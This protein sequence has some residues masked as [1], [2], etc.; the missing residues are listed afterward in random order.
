[1]AWAEGKEI[2]MRMY[3]GYAAAVALALGAGSQA[4]SAQWYYTPDR[5][6]NRAVVAQPLPLTQ[7][8]RTII[9][10]TII[11]QGR[12]RGPIV[13]EQIVTEPVAPAVPMVRER[14]YAQDYAY[15]VDAYAY[16]GYAPAPRERYVV[17]PDAN[18]AYAY[19]V[20]TRVPPTARLAPMP[21]ALVAQVPAVRSYQYMVVAGRLLLVDPNTGVV[22]AEVAR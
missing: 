16:G 18:A 19:A 4:A 11:P 3:F 22:V 14:A 12:G 13:R 2:I 10:R 1:L 5:V 6:E 20:G 9:Y 8:Q 17:E 15:D 21:P 7:A